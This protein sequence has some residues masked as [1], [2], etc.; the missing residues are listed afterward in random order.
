MGSFLVFGLI[1]GLV[2]L[3]TEEVKAQCN[4]LN[5]TF[6]VNPVLSPTNVDGAWYPDRYP[7]AGFSSGTIG[8]SDALKISIS[9]AD[10]A[11]N[12]PPAY[13]GQ[14][15]NTQGR[16][17]N[18]CGKCVTSVKGDIWI[19]ADWATKHRRTDMWATAFDIS[20]AISA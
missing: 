12:R 17:L 8:G 5:E 1:A 20:D 18:Q 6:N 10:G 4:L 7:P 11:Q 3:S 15:Y 9:A 14:F 16:K 13:S 19:P 2:T